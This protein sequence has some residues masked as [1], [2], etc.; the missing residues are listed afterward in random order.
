MEFLI[1]RASKGHGASPL[2]PLK[3]RKQFFLTFFLYLKL[4]FPEFRARW[5]FAFMEFVYSRAW[6]VGQGESGLMHLAGPVKTGQHCIF[7]QVFGNKKV[8]G[9]IKT[10]EN[11]VQKGFWQHENQ[12]LFQLLV[13]KCFTI[14]IF[15]P[16]LQIHMEMTLR[17]QLYIGVVL[18]LI[19]TEYCSSDLQYPI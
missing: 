14:C 11:I 19:K 9:N 8:F 12:A 5:L 17:S 6:N 2:S 15:L 18:V 10:C 4:Y 3:Y 1:S 7:A 16:G 13:W